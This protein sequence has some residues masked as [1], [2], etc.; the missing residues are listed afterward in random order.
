MR[1][2]LSELDKVEFFSDPDPVKRAQKQMK[3]PLVKRFF[4]T[5]SID[6]RDG[7]YLVLL[8][9]KSVKTPTRNVLALPT[10]NA[11]KL[12]AAEFEAQTVEIN[13]TK[14][15][16]TRLANTALDG[17]VN[18]IEAVLEDIKR[19]CGNDLICYRADAPDA[20]VLR[21][22]D[23]WDYYLNWINAE[24]GVRLILTEGV[25][26]VEQP[27][28]SVEAFGSALQPFREALSLACLHSITTLLGSAVIGL[29]V[30]T[31]KV[32][33]HEGWNAAHLDEDWTIE[34]WGT[35]DEAVYRRAN[36]WIEMDAAARML[37]AV[38]QG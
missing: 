25:M 22:R 18:E 14:M 1:E 13:P 11:V 3:T 34:N 6:E 17:V 32:T 7:A 31:G 28:E 12:V 38:Q 2:F 30:A 9:G 21:Q 4:T 29:A 15:P 26:H 5:V 10:K 23:R 24:Y 27:T 33:A 16:F 19:F 20:L 36:R 8:D 35:D 37:V